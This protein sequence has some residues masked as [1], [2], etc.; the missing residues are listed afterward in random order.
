MG[1]DLRNFDREYEAFG[2]SGGPVVDRARR[3]ASVEGRV[4]LDGG[5]LSRIVREKIAWLH[6][7]WIERTFPARR[8]EGRSAEKNSRQR[9]RAI[10]C[11]RVCKLACLLQFLHLE[12]CRV[13]NRLN[14]WTLWVHR[15]ERL[16]S[17]VLPSCRSLQKTQSARESR[18]RHRAARY[19]ELYFELF[20]STQNALE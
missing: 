14:F 1:D 9:K 12:E 16:S 17:F 11:E 20:C 7:P 3:R 15:S 8:R 5:K 19:F 6:A 18:Y 10:N 2:S 13:A 4:H